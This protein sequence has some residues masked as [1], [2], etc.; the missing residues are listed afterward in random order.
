MSAEHYTDREHFL[1][2]R[3]H[4][5][6]MPIRRFLPPGSTFG[7]D[8]LARM[9]ATFEIA[10]VQLRIEDRESNAARQV[11]LRVITL[12]AHERDPARLR[13]HAVEWYKRE[14]ASA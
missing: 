14:P 8:E 2:R 13:E 9:S 1:V 12:A 10:L 6:T 11:A 7:P 5:Q 4:N 3:C